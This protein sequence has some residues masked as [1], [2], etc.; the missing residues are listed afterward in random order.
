[1]NLVTPLL[2]CA[3]GFLGMEAVTYVV[4][5]FV[6]HGSLERLHRSH[7]R[8]A[9][10]AFARKSPEPNDVFPLAFSVVVVG[11]LALGFNVSG[12]AWLLPLL[13]GVTLYGLVYTVI[14]DGIIHGRIKW[15]KRVHSSWAISLGSAHREHHRSNGEPYGML[16]PWITLGRDAR[17]VQALRSGSLPSHVPVDQ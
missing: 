12:F 4:H 11:G 8:N 5:R 2:L 16:F 15:M 14:H 9:A 1:M 10:A 13:V 6:M 17:S 3:V 7:H